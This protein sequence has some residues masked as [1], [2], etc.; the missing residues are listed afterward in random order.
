MGGLRGADRLSRSASGASLPP[1]DWNKRSVTRWSY[2][3]E[4][5]RSLG[6]HWQWSALIDS[7]RTDSTHTSNC[8]GPCRSTLWEVGSLLDLPCA[9]V[10]LTFTPFCFGLFFVL[11]CCSRCTGHPRYS[12]KKEGRDFLLRTNHNGARFSRGALAAEALINWREAA[13]R[14]PVCFR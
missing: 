8:V 2:W 14:N 6:S 4:V 10:L 1:C 9:C 12:R 5:F 3:L 11:S 13:A 7:A